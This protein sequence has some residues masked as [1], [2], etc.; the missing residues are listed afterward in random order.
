M[1]NEDTFTPNYDPKMAR[2]SLYP[3]A[4]GEAYMGEDIATQEATLREF[5]DNDAFEDAM[6][7]KAGLCFLQSVKHD[8]ELIR[9]WI[10]SS[11]DLLQTDQEWFWKT[12]QKESEKYSKQIYN[13]QTKQ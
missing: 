9:E 13:F 1:K 3:L 10:E 5:A 12:M 2:L 11:S 7:Y 8:K 4:I 6:V